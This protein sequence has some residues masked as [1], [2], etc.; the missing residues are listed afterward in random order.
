DT[1]TQ[2]NRELMNLSVDLSELD[3]RSR[4]INDRI[5]PGKIEEVALNL[6]QY[7]QDK[8]EIAAISKKLSDI[9][10]LL[11]DADYDMRSQFVSLRVVDS[12]NTPA[13]GK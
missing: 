13:P 11:E 2:W 1:L 5:N 4:A 10:R 6:F 7:E 8:S 9:D 12:A 3:A